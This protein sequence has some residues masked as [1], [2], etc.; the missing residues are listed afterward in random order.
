MEIVTSWQRQGRIEGR[1]EGK[2]EM[3]LRQL[4]R[5]VGTLTPQ[6]QERIQ[7]LSVSQ[8]EDLGEALLDFNAIADLE[9][10][11]ATHTN[12]TNS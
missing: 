3:V 6:L 12:D 2:R 11:L 5:R 9:N 1:I 10:W 7:R 4:N 8:L